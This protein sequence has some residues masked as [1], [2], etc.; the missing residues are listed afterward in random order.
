[1]AWITAQSPKLWPYMSVSKFSLACIQQH[2]RIYPTT[3]SDLHLA[4][5][6]YL[7]P[8]I[9]TYLMIYRSVSSFRYVSICENNCIYMWQNMYQYVTTDLNAFVYVYEYVFD[10]ITHVCVYLCTGLYL[11]IHWPISEYEFRQNSRE[12][13]LYSMRNG[14]GHSLS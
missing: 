1:M 12:K 8:H 6:K 5:C 11:T 9:H 13:F 14:L 7:W 2:P 4:P 10:V 3:H